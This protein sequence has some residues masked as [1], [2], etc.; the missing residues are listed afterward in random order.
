MA[1]NLQCRKVS[2]KINKDIFGQPCIDYIILFYFP[3]SLPQ[4]EM[5]NPL[6]NISLVNISGILFRCVF[7]IIY[8]MICIKKVR[9]ENSRNSH[10]LIYIYRSESRTR[11]DNVENDYRFSE[12]LHERTFEIHWFR[13]LYKYVSLADS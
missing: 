8:D 13:S 6:T 1:A 4:I 5:G 2:L 9:F 3:F 7:H 10:E 12:A 11:K